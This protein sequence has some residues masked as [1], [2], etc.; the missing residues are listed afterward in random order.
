MGDRE[1]AFEEPAVKKVVGVHKQD[2]LALCARQ[3]RIAR[4]GHPFALL[5]VYDQIIPTRRST[6]EHA[7]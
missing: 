7:D 4:G 3:T 2:V 5:P 6:A 1:H